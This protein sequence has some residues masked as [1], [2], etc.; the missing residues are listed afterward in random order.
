MCLMSLAL[1]IALAGLRPALSVINFLPNPARAL[2]GAAL[3]RDGLRSGPKVSKKRHEL[4]GA[5]LQA[6]GDTRRAPTID[7]VKRSTGCSVASDEQRG[8]LQGTD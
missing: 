3:C 7:R 1:V 8:N 4:P 6:H 2:V 5:T